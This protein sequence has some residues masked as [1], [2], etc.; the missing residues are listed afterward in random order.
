MILPLPSRSV[1]SALS[2]AEKKMENN[3]TEL[4]TL[5]AVAGLDEQYH[6]A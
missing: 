3:Y 5:G 6:E 4:K 1:S 2:R